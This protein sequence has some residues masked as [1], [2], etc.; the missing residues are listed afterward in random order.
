MNTLSTMPKANAPQQKRAI[1]QSVSEQ[2]SA[3]NAEPHMRSPSCACG[4][5]CP[6]CKNMK[7]SSRGILQAKLQVGAPDDAYEKE[8]D[9]VA[10]E[11]L[12]TPSSNAISSKAPPLIQRLTSQT[13]GYKTTAPPSVESVLS[14]SGRSLDPELQDDMSQRFGENFSDV[15]I[16]T[17]GAAEQSAQEINAHAYTV[18]RDIVFGAGQ[19]SPSS[20]QG[21]RLLAHELTHV[22]QQRSDINRQIIQRDI[23]YRGEGI[24]VAPAAPGSVIHD[25]GDGLYMT[26][27]PAVA[28]EYAALRSGSMQGSAPLV[29]SANIESSTLGRV[30]NLLSDAR[31]QQFLAESPIP[32]GPTHQALIQ[33]ANE[34]YEPIFQAFLQRNNLHL[35]N[36]DAVIG[37]EFVRGGTQICV[38]NTSIISQVRAL[39]RPYVPSATSAAASGSASSASDPATAPISVATRYNILNSTI[40]EAGNTIAEV[41]I[42][43]GRGAEDLSRVSGGTS[44]PSR[45]VLRITTTAEGAFVGAESVGIELSSGVTEA[46]ARQI[47][48][49]L[50]E[51]AA[52]GS[53]GAVVS[54]AATAARTSRWVRGLGWAGIILF[55]AA[56]GYQYSQATTDRARRRVLVTA[57][58]GL[59]GGAIGTYVVCNLIF[60]IETFGLSLIGCSLVAGG[61]GAYIASEASGEVYDEA[62]ATPLERSLHELESRPE[63]VRRLFF[64]MLDSNGDLNGVALSNEFVREFMRV[65]PSGISQ[66]EVSVLLGN[67]RQTG[68][69]DTTASIIA[70][71]QTAIGQLPGRRPASLSA[72]LEIRDV[73]GG[74][75][76]FPT[77]ID[78]DI[79]IPLGPM[80]LLPPPRSLPGGLG[81]D[82]VPNDRRISPSLPAAEISF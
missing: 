4:G 66:Y 80:R 1:A 68:S 39:L 18:G 9:R 57:G 79:S 72:P 17:G 70:A 75:A 53:E 35:E 51:A 3:S 10:D 27:S 37:Q 14:G 54:T 50:P 81:G 76:I 25:F 64:G 42:L 59:A 60:G 21:K 48:A 29:L 82:E 63:M 45:I 69:T 20:Q 62:T 32:G 58:S 43:L 36:F 7:N 40:N 74:S 46:L 65:V 78:I 19:F 47:V 22:V 26:D 44:M 12:T 67:L 5:G 33:M 77:H 15:R 13:N 71:L 73:T 28:A 30:L 11:I 38:R 41:E 23:W 52:V 49:T 8:A 61:A 55:I 16:H 31:W 6:S 24:G 2:M 34:N 56:T